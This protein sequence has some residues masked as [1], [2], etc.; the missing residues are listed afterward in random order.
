MADFYTIITATV[1]DEDGDSECYSTKLLEGQDQQAEIDTAIAEAVDRFKENVTDSPSSLR[2]VVNI[3][4][5]PAPRVPFV[6]VTADVPE[7]D[8]PAIVEAVVLK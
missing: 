8:A 5:V 7:G 2:A 4:R 1:I 3:N 6:V